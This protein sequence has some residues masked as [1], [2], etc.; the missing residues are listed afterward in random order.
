M[1]LLNLSFTQDEVKEAQSDNFAPIPAGNY[2]AE[3][4]RSEIKQTKDGRGSYLSLSLKVLEGDFAGR[5]IFQ[6]ITLTNASATAQ[7]IG[8]EQMA[9]LAGAC[10]VLN[11]QDSEQLHG[12][13][14]GIRVAIETDKTGQYEPRNSVKK[15][16]PLNNPMQSTPQFGQPQTAPAAQAPQ[17]NPWARQG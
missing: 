17:G 16:F 5:L 10:G 2:T 12:I 4:N 11:L 6:N 9:Q 8:R 14:M 7:N 13:A 3:V 15:F 1:A